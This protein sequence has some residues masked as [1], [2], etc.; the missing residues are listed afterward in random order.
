MRT[1]TVSRLHA[2]GAAASVH[3]SRTTALA[4]VLMASLL[5]PV[6]TASPAQAFGGASTS[7]TPSVTTAKQL[8]SASSKVATG[9]T[10]AAVTS[11]AT[12]ARPAGLK[13]PTRKHPLP[14]RIL[15]TARKYDGSY[16]RHG[17][18]TPAGFDCSGYTRYVFAKLGKSLPHNSAAQYT[19]VKHVGRSHARAGDLIFFR[20]GSGHIYHVGIFVGHGKLYHASQNGVRTGLGSIYSSNVSFGRV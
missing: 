6:T 14:T 17:G 11:A 15:A 5:V 19:V 16:Y 20:S 18:T 10:T 13:K 4:L 7:T 1:F 9:A 8:A 12:S 2:L 3:R